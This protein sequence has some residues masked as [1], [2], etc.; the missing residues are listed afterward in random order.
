MRSAQGSHLDLLE[1][2]YLA[3]ILK[4][5][6]TFSRKV[7]EGSL[8]LVFGPIRVFPRFVPV[9]EIDAERLAVVDETSDLRA[10][11]NQTQGVPLTNWLGKVSGRSQAV[12]E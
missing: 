6:S 11:A 12:I 1:P 2:D 8:K 3:V 5:Y 9:V 7:A 4:A 10:I